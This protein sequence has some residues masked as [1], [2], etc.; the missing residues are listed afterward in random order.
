MPALRDLYRSSL[1]LVCPSV[2]EFGIVMAEAHATGTP[3]I[4]PNAGGACEIVEDGV[5]GLLLDRLDARSLATAVEAAV[6]HRF[7]PSACRASAER[8]AEHRF[9]AALDRVLGEELAL[10]GDAGQPAAPFRR[11]DT[12][13]A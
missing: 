9:T 2:E 7:D 4:A 13:A 11:A 3:V 6:R 1:A 10:A 12:Q 5:T 8:F